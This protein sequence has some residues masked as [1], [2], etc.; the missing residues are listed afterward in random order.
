MCDVSLHKRPGS[1]APTF[2][3]STNLTQKHSNVLFLVS[4]FLLLARYHCLGS[5]GA[6]FYQCF[7]F[8]RNIVLNPSWDLQAESTNDLNSVS[9]WGLVGIIGFLTKLSYQRSEQGSGQWGQGDWK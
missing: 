2:I 3:K 1:P 7:P 6:L 9:F 4:L 8:V 5:T